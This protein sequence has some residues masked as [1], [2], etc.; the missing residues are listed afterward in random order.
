MQQ[1]QDPHSSPPVRMA[2]PSDYRDMPAAQANSGWPKVI[3][4]IAIVFGALGTVNGVMGFVGQFVAEK[5]IDIVPASQREALEATKELGNWYIL[6]YLV[7]LVLGVV[8]IVGGAKLVGRK[9]GSARIL[10]AWSWLKI[11]AS[12][13]SVAVAWQGIPA[14]VAA[15][16]QDPNMQRSGMSTAMLEFILK[17]GFVAFFLWCIALPVFLLIWFARRTIKD[18]IRGWGEAVAAERGY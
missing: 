3:G 1:Y 17:L 12:V 16:Q 10:R 7:R 14:Q 11:L 6:D 5:I 15:M 13:Y 18:E 8:L 4:I 9:P 2:P